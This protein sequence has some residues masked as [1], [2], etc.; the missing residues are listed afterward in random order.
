MKKLQRLKLEALNNML[1]RDQMKQITGGYGPCQGYG[2]SCGGGCCANLHC[3]Y[4]NFYTYDPKN[5]TP[6]QCVGN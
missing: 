2:N 3:G 1:T 4:D 6:P 5:P